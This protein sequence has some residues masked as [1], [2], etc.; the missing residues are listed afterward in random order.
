MT[1]DPDLRRRA[2][3]WLASITKAKEWQCLRRDRN[4]GGI[5]YQ[6]FADCEPDGEQIAWVQS[7]RHDAEFIAAAPLLLRDLLALIADQA[8]QIADSEAALRGP[9]I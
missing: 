2:E 7:T 8:Q 6:I 5:E 4:D 3:Q 1:S 9:D